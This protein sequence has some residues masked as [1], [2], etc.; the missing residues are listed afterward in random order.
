M[1]G[2]DRNRPHGHIGVGTGSLSCIGLRPLAFVQIAIV[3]PV[4]WF[5]FRPPVSMSIIRAAMSEAAS[6]AFEPN[7][8]A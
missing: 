8:T 7:E 2:A 4:S 1:V 5:L 3:P 6:K